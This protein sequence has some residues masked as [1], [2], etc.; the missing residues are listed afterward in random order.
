[1][2]RN[3]LERLAKTLAQLVS[4]L[5][6]ENV[7]ATDIRFFSKSRTQAVASLDYAVAAAQRLAD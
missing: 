4:E 2:R 5:P 7:D 1:M 6:A 3:F